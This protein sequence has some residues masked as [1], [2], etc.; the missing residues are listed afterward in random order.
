M[1]GDPK[2]LSDLNKI[3]ADVRIICRRCGFEEDWTT[4][5][6][7]RHLIAIGGNQ[8]WS[9]ITRYLSCR[10]VGCGSP[11]L[12]HIAVPYARRQPNL[13]R[14]IGALDARL[15][16]TAV[17]ILEEA[18]ARSPRTAV[19]TIE[20]HLALLVVHRYI[21][22]RE[23]VR[24]FWELAANGGRRV[25]DTLRDRLAVIRHALEK[26]GWIAPRV[27]TEK[28]RTW[29]WQSPPPRGWVA[30]PGCAHSHEPE[31]PG[32]RGDPDQP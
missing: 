28:A 29:G 3:E 23:A 9:E 5:D 16:A 1:V 21:R 7:A 20:V 19:D 32:G 17:T 22:D 14:Q 10:R 12:R 2:R 24:R 13:P 31:E 30:G 18:T 25:D 27:L 6:L 4:G 15:I 26:G 11:D 8:A